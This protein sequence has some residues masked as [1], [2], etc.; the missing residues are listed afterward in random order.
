VYSR[1]KK[2]CNGQTECPTSYQKCPCRSQRPQRISMVCFGSP[3][4]YKRDE[5]A[6]SH[7]ARP[8]A[9]RLITPPS[10]GS[11]VLLAISGAK[12]SALGQK[13]RFEPQLVTPGLATTLDMSLA[14]CREGPVS[15]SRSGAITLSARATKPAGIARSSSF[16][17]SRLMTNSQCVTPG[18][19]PK[20]RHQLQCL[21]EEGRELLAP[22]LVPQVGGRTSYS[23]ETSLPV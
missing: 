20:R 22:A 16:A 11:Y 12:L 6:P 18:S 1:Y 3:P 14:N 4:N 8:T 19:E 15:D 7:G 23:V 17:A 21:K 10:A 9:R 13:R 2:N 5:V